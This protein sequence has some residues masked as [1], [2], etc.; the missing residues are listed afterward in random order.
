MV[1]HLQFLRMVTTAALGHVGDH[2]TTM[3]NIEDKQYAVQF[4]NIRGRQKPTITQL[5]IYTEGSKT[6]QGVGACFVIIDG[7]DTAIYM[8]SI[9]LGQNWS[10]F[11]AQLIAI[12]EAALY[13][14]QSLDKRYYIKIFSY[15]Q[16]ALMALRQKTCKSN[17]VKQTHD[18]PNQLADTHKNQRLA[19]IKAHVDME[20][21][22]LAD[23]YARLRTNDTAKQIIRNPTQKEI[24][25]LIQGYIYHKWREK[26]TALKK[27]RMTKIFYIEP[28]R[29]VGRVVAGLRKQLSMYIKAGHNNLNYMNGIMIP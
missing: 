23:E 7:K 18:A 16:D 6:K 9:N 11:Q 8:E 25:G 20:G 4:D 19:W 14:A 5:N 12:Q 2:D 27:G 29:Q 15:S 13:T 28:S 10:I 17:I 21:N 1:L 3:D 26:W 24:K 22:K